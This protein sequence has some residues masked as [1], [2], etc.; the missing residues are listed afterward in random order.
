MFNELNCSIF[1]AC[2]KRCTQLHCRH[3]SDRK[4]H[5]A[6]YQSI[7]TFL[8]GKM[9]T[10]QMLP[11]LDGNAVGNPRLSRSSTSASLLP[12]SESDITQN[13]QPSTAI[14]SD[15]NLSIK[16]SLST[17]TLQKFTSL[18]STARKISADTP[19]LDLEN[20]LAIPQQIPRVEDLPD[21]DRQ[22]FTALSEQKAQLENF[23]TNAACSRRFNDVRVLQGNLEEINREMERLLRRQMN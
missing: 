3:A 19:A 7:Q 1:M 16:H 13:G 8:H 23:I 17:G 15:A 21:A 9:F 10:L 11:R 14:S 4:L 6:I 20:I 22:A 18:F 5:N 2:S 12:E